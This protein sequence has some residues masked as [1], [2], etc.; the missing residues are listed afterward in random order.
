[1]GGFLITYNRAATYLLGG[2]IMNS[3]L[4]QLL[5]KRWILKSEDKELYYKVRDSIGEIRKFASD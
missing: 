5:N 3:E 1:M 4:E 2:I